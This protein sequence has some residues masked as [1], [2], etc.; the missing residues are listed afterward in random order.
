MKRVI[1]LKK[2]IKAA[3]VAAGI[4][5][6]VYSAA[7]SL[8]FGFSI[9]LVPILVLSL[10]FILYGIFFDRLKKSAHISFACAGLVFISVCAGLAFYGN[11]DNV[12]YTEEAVI[13][14]GK[15]LDGDKV[16]PDLAYRLDRAVEYHEKNPD[17][18]IVVSGGKGTDEEISEALAMERYLSA[19]GVYSEKIIKE[20]KSTSTYENFAFSSKIIQQKLGTD[21]SVAF[22]TNKFHVY[23]AE[24][25]AESVGLNAA[26]LGADIEWYN[27]PTNYMR[28]LIALAENFI[29]RTK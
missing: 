11:N 26:H 6:A 25:L 18:I 4:L 16:T 10:V 24:K 13:V 1:Y 12:T 22:I 29:F 20:D 3:A 7:M 14:L 5:M 2:S 23:R 15:G 9:G 21:Y 8:V 17:A 28:E 27:V 19:K